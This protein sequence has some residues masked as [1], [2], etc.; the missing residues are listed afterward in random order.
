MRTRIFKAAWLFLTIGALAFT[1]FKMDN[2]ESR[3]LDIVLIWL[4][5]LLC[6][7]ASLVGIYLSAGLAFSA[8]SI[9]PNMPLC[10]EV[11]LIWAVYFV[12]GYLQWFVLLPRGLRRWAQKSCSDP[13][14]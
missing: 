2:G 4:M 14:H 10:L 6:F 9:M 8:Q 13:P 5:L 11:A 12:L 1:C 7:P 3:D